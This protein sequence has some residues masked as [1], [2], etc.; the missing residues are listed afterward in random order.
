MRQPVRRTARRPR[1]VHPGWVWRGAV[2]VMATALGGYIGWHAVSP[3]LD[4]GVP[5]GPTDVAADTAAEPAVAT[6]GAD[7]DGGSAASTVARNDR[8]PSD[9][10]HDSGIAGAPAEAPARKRGHDSGPTSHGQGRAGGHPFASGATA[11]VD[12]EPDPVVETPARIAVPAINVAAPVVTLGLRQDGRLEVP[13][14]FDTTGWWQGGASPGEHGP[15]VIAGHVDSY[16][17][18]AVFHRLHQLAPGDEVEIHGE[19]GDTVRFEVD[20]VQQHAKTA[21]PTD[22]VYG[23]TPQPTLRLITCG[24]PFDETRNRYQDNIIVYATRLPGD[25]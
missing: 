10:G 7:T 19:D 25:G 13:S 3:T 17:G 24:G 11:A 6:T 15:A 21:F 20:S 12:H 8:S 18:P 4:A 14:D 23:D 22:D 2:V 5:A 16:T 9:R 1:S